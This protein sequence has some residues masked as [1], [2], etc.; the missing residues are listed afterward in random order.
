MNMRDVALEYLKAGLTPIPIALDGSKAPHTFK[1]EKAPFKW[2]PLVKKPPTAKQ[3][4]KL[5]SEACG[6]GIL[7]GS[8]SGGLEIVDFDVGTAY[9]PW[10]ELVEQIAPGLLHRLPTVKTPN[11]Y[12]VYFRS[13]SCGPNQKLAT[14]AEVV[15]GKK[16]K[17]IIETRGQGGYVIA[18]PSPPSVH[19]TG[20]AYGF[21]GVSI[22]ATPWITEQEREV[23]LSAARSFTEV[24]ELTEKK[25]VT[26]PRALG[27]AAKPGEDF[28]D[29]ADWR[30]VLLPHGWQ[31]L[32]TVGEKTYWRRPGKNEGGISATTGFCGNKLYVFTSN[33]PP[34]EPGRAYNKFTAYGRLNHGG[35]FSAAS[36]DLRAK[37]FG[38]PP[39]QAPQ[40]RKPTAS[41]WDELNRGLDSI[42]GPP[43]DAPPPTD[44]DA[45]EAPKLKPLTA[46]QLEAMMD[47][48]PAA[49]IAVFDR[50]M[51]MRDD[52]FEWARICDVLRRKK[53]K[54][55][56]DKEVRH[57]EAVQK[58]KSVD[59]EGW[60]SNMLY[61]KNKDGDLV[62]ETCLTNVVE[63]LMNDDAWAGV[64]CFDEFRNQIV[65]RLQPPYKR[66]S[67]QWADEDALEVKMWLE[68]S[69][70]IRPSIQLVCEAVLVAAKRL[71]FHPLRD[72]LD[73]VEDDG[74]ES[75]IDTWLVDC[76]GA[77]DTP[78]TRAVGRKWLI[79]AVARAYDPGCKVDTVLVLE[80]EQGMKKSRALNQLCPEPKW[81]CDG[82]SELG[83]SRQAEE[84]EGKW[85]IEL[86]E[87]KGVGRDLEQTKAFVTRQAENYRPAYARYAVYR[88]RSC[89]FAGTVNPGNNGYLKD[90]T[91]NRRWWPVLCTKQAP[92]IT[93]ELRDRLWAEAKSL[94]RAGEK[95]W[96]EEK[97]LIEAA[98]EEQEARAFK[99]PWHERVEMF[100]LGKYET[101]VDEI[102][103]D[104]IK[105][106]AAKWKSSDTQQVGR[107]MMAMKWKRYRK[108][109]SDG[110]K[111]R[112][113][114]TNPPRTLFPG[115]NGHDHASPFS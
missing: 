114:H 100:L 30:D 86:G 84:I 66:K 55:D 6:I 70:P 105:L 93:P 49:W 103:E 56:F 25:S 48:E 88:P 65:T 107:I 90:E 79:S 51:A 5:F 16:S 82:L 14:V 26:K 113:K 9:A 77:P 7:G 112:Y 53:K 33:A 20:L 19:P 37:G 31:E 58:R 80:G 60:K 95:W 110:L 98:E 32:R 18:P 102:L 109:T 23:L 29:R 43:M 69:Y 21:L 57:W 89:V 28:D 39:K 41:Q 17:C 78:Y 97:E 96:I 50:I 3:I 64:I 24:P 62:L 73:S 91:G 74:G 38:A 47:D 2:Q 36:A 76:F 68:R 99:E 11:G 42:S 12:H 71:A 111:W 92:E 40:V 101:S 67:M 59:S 63:I 61:R 22:I 15:S 13:D 85:I 83:S 44:D 52:R 104:C 27:A 94:Y 34:F 87:L 108:R 72:Y 35:D 54:G 10:A 106:E 46:D 115:G 8:T 81:F 75:A 1:G 45:P 4:E